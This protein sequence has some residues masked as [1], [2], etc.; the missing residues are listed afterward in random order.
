MKPIV[1][2]KARFHYHLL[3][4]YETGIALTGGEVKAIKSGRMDLSSAYVSVSSHELYLV[5]ANIPPYKFAAAS[6]DYNPTKP[7]KLLMHKQEIHFLEGKLS[8]KG[9]TL[10]PVKVYTKR[11]RVKVA[12]ALAKGKGRVDK[13]ESILKRETERKIG[14]IIRG[15]YDRIRE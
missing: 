9:L 3:E 7:R 1:N 8:G 6:I 12:I 11:N 14:R 2:R 13:R 15:K 5:G 4:E 10:I